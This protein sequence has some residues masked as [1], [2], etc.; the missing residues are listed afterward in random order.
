MNSF[1]D[2]KAP[3]ELNIIES[4]GDFF[5]FVNGKSDGL[6]AM[7]FSDSEAFSAGTAANGLEVDLR[8]IIDL[9]A[10]RSVEFVND[11]SEDRGE[12]SEKGFEF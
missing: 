4:V 10:C 6:L 11:E 5:V 2:I 7:R 9:V 1:H 12:W 8:G 3:P